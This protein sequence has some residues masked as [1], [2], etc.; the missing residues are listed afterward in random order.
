MSNEP[1]AWTACFTLTSI[2]EV[3]AFI[4]RVGQNWTLKSSTQS[5]SVELDKKKPQVPDIEYVYRLELCLAA[6]NRKERK[7]PNSNL[8]KSFI[9]N[10]KQLYIFMGYQLQY[11]KWGYTLTT[12]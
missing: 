11:F 1:F 2:G 3:S 10:Y 5:Q 7:K 6:S 12:L 8:K 9:F 4:S